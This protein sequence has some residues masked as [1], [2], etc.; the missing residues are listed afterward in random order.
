MRKTYPSEIARERFE[1]IRP[2]LKSAR[3]KAKPGSVDLY[4]VLNCCTC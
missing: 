3:K 1:R 4:D 2:I